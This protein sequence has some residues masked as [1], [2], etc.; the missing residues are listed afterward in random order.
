MY[1][2]KLMNTENAPCFLSVG[3]SLTTE[4]GGVSS[5]F[6]G[7]ILFAKPFVHVKGRDGL[8]RG[9]NEILFVG[10]IQDLWRVSIF[11]L[12]DLYFIKLLIK[13]LELSCLG[14]DIFVHKEGRL[15]WCIISF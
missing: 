13:V 4:T 3:P 5:V 7:E 2:F 10:T 8:F 15:N 6:L 1:F 14:H 11:S 9:G 12:L